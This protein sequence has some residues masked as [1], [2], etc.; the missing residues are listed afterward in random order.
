MIPIRMCGCGRRDDCKGMPSKLKG[1]ITSKEGR[2]EKVY[3]RETGKDES[4]KPKTMGGLRKELK[5][6]QAAR[7]Q[8]LFIEQFGGL[9]WQQVGKEDSELLRLFCALGGA[10]FTFEAYSKWEK[11]TKSRILKSSGQPED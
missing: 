2:G 1:V 10:Y 5:N 8:E 4:R 6:K 7:A 11:A 9:S 3:G